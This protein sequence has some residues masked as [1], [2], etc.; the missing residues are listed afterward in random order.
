MT[1][2]DATL[3]AGALLVPG[4][5]LA[6]LQLNQQAAEVR[7]GTPA[8][9]RAVGAGFA[10]LPPACLA[11]ALL[12]LNTPGLIGGEAP[13]VQRTTLGVVALATALGFAGVPFTLLRP[14]RG[15]ALAA[16]PPEPTPPS[17]ETPTAALVLELSAD[18][19]AAPDRG[20][21]ELVRM[22]RHY[23]ELRFG[24]PRQADTAEALRR[25]QELPEGAV[26]PLR[27]ILRTGDRVRFGAL[28]ADPR[29]VV[30]LREELLSFVR[31]T[32]ADHPSRKA[33]G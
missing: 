31:S 33:E 4:G 12:A 15:A 22:T 21:L 27:R 7:G 20:I 10:L 8:L 28:E 32:R 14:P 24:I 19:P 2:L 25:L 18:L 17:P 26:A 11:V 3:W 13:I 30:T 23:L 1:P 6:A 29:L 5:L 16:A 9:R